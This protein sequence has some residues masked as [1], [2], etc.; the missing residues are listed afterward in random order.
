MWAPRRESPPPG[1]SQCES[2]EGK[3]YPSI[4][5]E[6]QAQRGVWPGKAAFCVPCGSMGAAGGGLEP[7]REET[8]TPPLQMSHRPISG[9]S[10]NAAPDTQ[11]AAAAVAS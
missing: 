9:A 8:T 3:N 10:R 11:D 7:Q 2:G 6:C 4:N 5:D 1:I